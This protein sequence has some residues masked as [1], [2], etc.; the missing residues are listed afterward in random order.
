LGRKIVVDWFISDTHFY[1]KNIIRFAERPFKDVDEMNQVMVD[2]W[3]DRV[4]KDDL[5]FHLGD[6]G[7]F[8]SAQQMVELMSELNGRKVLI[9]GNHDRFTNSQYHAAGFEDIYNYYRYPV[10]DPHGDVDFWL[11]MTHKPTVL[12]PG[13]I[14]LVGHIHQQFVYQGNNL[15]MSVEVWGYQPVNLLEIVGRIHWLQENVFDTNTE[16]KLF[17]KEKGFNE[18][19]RVPIPERDSNEGE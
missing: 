6:I 8:R 5:V 15:N 10:P 11:E 16:M 3:N 2:N 14:N 19:L 1:H 13:P 9:K 18:P 17:G 7:F 4:D 12:K